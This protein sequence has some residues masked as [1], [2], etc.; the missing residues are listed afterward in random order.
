MLRN[1]A[2]RAGEG[3]LP[4]SVLHLEIFSSDHFAERKLKLPFH[5]SQKLPWSLPKE[6]GE[7][8]RLGGTQAV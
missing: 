2:L 5:L 3:L 7:S 4:K 8:S 6:S 1:R